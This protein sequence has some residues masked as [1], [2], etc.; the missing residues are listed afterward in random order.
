LTVKDLVEKYKS[1]A[2]H[3]KSADYNEAQLRSDFLDPFFELLG[4]DIKNRNRKRTYEREVILEES[5]RTNASESTKKPDYTFRFFSERK[6]FLE[7]KK[8]H[9]EIQNHSKAAKQIRRYGFTARLK[10]SVLSNFEY[11]IIYDCSVKVDEDDDYMK[12][13]IKVYHYSEYEEKFGELKSYIGRESIYTGQFDQVWKKIEDNINRFCI[14]DLFLEHINEWR[15]LLGIEICRYSPGISTELLNDHVQNYLNSIIFLRVCEDRELEVSGSLLKITRE[16]NFKALLD[17]FVEAD[18]KYNAGLF[19]LFLADK[20]IEN[21]HSVFWKIIKELYYPESPYSFSVFSSE[22]LGNIYEILLAET[23]VI[24]D[25]CVVLEKKPET[26]DKDIITTPTYIIREILKQT[27]VPYC[28]GKNDLE[29]LETRV[30]DISCGSGAFLLEAYQLLNDLLIDYYLETDTNKL[31]QT[32]VNSYKLPF[33]VKKKLLV[34]CIYGVDKD[35]NAVEAAKFGLLLKLLEDETNTSVGKQKPLLPDLSNNIV[36][37]N[38]LISPHDIDHL[39]DFTKKNINPFDFKNNTYDIIIG[40]P[41]YMKSEDMKRVTPFEHPQP[42]KKIFASAYKQYDK[43]FLFIEKA[44]SLLKEDGCVGYIVPGKFAKVGAGKKLRHLLS[45]SGHLKKIISFGANQIFHSKTT[46]TC[47]LILGKRSS[48]HCGFYEVKNLPDWKITGCQDKDF[49][50]YLL[51]GLEDEVWVFVPHYFKHLFDEINAKSSPLIDLVGRDNV[52]NGIQTSKNSVYI[53]AP[54]KEDRHYI[55]FENKGRMWSVEKELTRP[56]Y[57]TPRKKSPD[58]LNTYRILEPNCKVIFPYKR[59]EK[60]I[61]IIREAELRV[62]YPNAYDYF[63]YF[64][65]DLSTRDVKPPIE[66]DD[67]YKFGRSQH[68][69]RWDSPSKIVIGVNSMGEKYAIDFSHTF[70]SSGGTAGYCGITVPTHTGYS[71]YYIQALLNSKYLEWYS[72]LIGEVFR[73][74]YIARGT[75]VLNKLPIRIIDFN[76]ADEKQ[77]HDAIAAIQEQLICQQSEI[78]KNRNDSR[79]LIKLQRQFDGLKAALNRMLKELY[80]LGDDDDLIPLINELYL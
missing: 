27:I 58:K 70:I 6:F 14:D 17:K 3:Y 30:S 26:I 78:D 63:C 57:K 42:Y 64:K 39:D 43:Y 45:Q 66:S 47:I 50:N 56:Y 11:L 12:A 4:W 54:V 20:I 38:A 71:I 74:G 29:I 37:G 48:E 32:G 19:Q 59:S 25:D 9:V 79:A 5:L 31:I 55:Y 23:L 77:V 52:F 34:N 36:Y 2:H 60:R 21:I 76:R 35:Y 67:W 62:K 16:G 28:E 13:R 75:K 40:N 80:G 46:Y 10:I 68:L 22:I 65:A 15:Q 49:E 7:A 33:E 73:G 24:K 51:S 44:L 72:S 69:D 61:E 1:D 18:R 41:P 8:P 53:V